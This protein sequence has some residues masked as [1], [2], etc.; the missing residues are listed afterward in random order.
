MF[1][2]I[3]IRINTKQRLLPNSLRSRNYKLMNKTELNKE[4]IQG[5]KEESIWEKR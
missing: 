1:Q 5:K 3:T 4:I 2:P